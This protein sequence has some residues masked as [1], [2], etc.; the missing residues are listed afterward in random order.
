MC[1]VGDCLCDVVWLCGLFVIRCA[2]LCDGWMC[3]VCFGCDVLC[4]AIWFDVLC[5]CLFPPHVRVCDV[6]L[7][8]RV[9]FVR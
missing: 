2:I 7:R 5:A 1:F 6:F 9:L 3:V 8:L 4:V